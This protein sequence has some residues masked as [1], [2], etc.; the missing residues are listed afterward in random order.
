MCGRFALGVESEQVRLGIAAHFGS[1][2]RVRRR[3]EPNEEEDEAYESM[4][5]LRGGGSGGEPVVAESEA[6]P[7]RTPLSELVSYRNINDFALTN[8]SSGSQSSVDDLIQDATA[9]SWPNEEKFRSNNYN[10]APR[11]HSVVLRLKKGK[12][13]AAATINDLQLDTMQWGLIPHWSK[14][15]PSGP[16]NTI[17]ARSENLM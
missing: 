11:S 14:H 12:G 3:G 13:K 5:R 15:P 8:L 7:S 16:L 10:V 17:N 4:G 9:L 6:G 1:I 2:G